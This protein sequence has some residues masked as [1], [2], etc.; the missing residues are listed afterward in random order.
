[1]VTNNTHAA[2]NRKGDEKESTKMAKKI[3]WPP[4]ALPKVCG[5]SNTLVIAL[6]VPT[7]SQLKKSLF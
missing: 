5:G 4:Q 3:F 1:M 2:Y 7:I 6:H